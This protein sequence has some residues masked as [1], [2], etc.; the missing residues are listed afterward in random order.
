MRLNP[1]YAAAVV[2]L[3]L[4]MRLLFFGVAQHWNFT[5]PVILG[6]DAVGYEQL[7]TTLLQHHRFA[8]RPTGTPDAL[9]TP[10]YPGFLAAIYAVVGVSPRSAMAVQILIDALSCLLL[11]LALTHVFGGRIAL[12][13]GAFYALD[14][15]L[16][17]Q[18]SSTLYSDT[19]FVFFMVLTLYLVSRA[20]AEP[21]GRRALVFYGLAGLA[22]GVGTLVRP[23]SEYL[24]LV[25]VVFFVVWYR[26]RPGFAAL[27]SMVCLFAFIVAL[28]PWVLRNER[29]FGRLAVSDSGQYNLLVLD[30]VPMVMTLRHQDALTVKTAL[31]AQADRNLAADSVLLQTANDFQQAD[32][33]QRLALQ[34]IKANPVR[35]GETY[36]LGVFDMFANLSTSTYTEALGLPSG[37]LDMKAYTSIPALIGAFFR[38][39]GLTS[40]LIAAVIGAYL[41]VSYVGAAVGLFVAWSRFPRG[42]VLFCLLAAAY[43][44]AVTGAGGLARFKLPA[45][46]FYL[47][48]S[49]IGLVWAYQ[50]FLVRRS[51]ERVAA[52]TTP[53]PKL[54]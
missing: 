6:G 34:Y 21:P 19:L 37:H 26:R 54:E 7:A 44:A 38:D 29:T 33:W 39:K 4:T 13:T 42:L 32:E 35:F 11:M 14:P 2:A 9:R 25:G 53:M 10:I 5:Q 22:I 52:L 48:F 28:S 50:R 15:F 20:L 24:P 51:T 30:V 36:A 47:G 16:F 45:I 18:S 40:L 41:L 12:I 8:L 17:A 43:F 27:C 1:R 3:C 31:L 49:A 46:P 23:V